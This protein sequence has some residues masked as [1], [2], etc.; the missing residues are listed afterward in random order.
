M[1]FSQRKGLKPIPQRLRPDQMPDELRSSL[2]NALHLSLWDSPGF[3]YTST[4]NYGA[5]TTFAR[6]LW[7]DYFKL[8][9]SG[10][11]SRPAEVI[12]WLQQYFF[13]CP[14]NEVYDFLEAVL[15]ATRNNKIVGHLDDVLK[16][17]LAAYRLIKNRVVEIT[18]EKEMAAL[19]EALQGG[20]GFAPA[21]AHLQQALE[22]LSDR[23]NPDFRNSIKE[24]IS[25]VEAAARAITGRQTATL[26][27]ALKVL[28]E[29]H[30]LHKAL[31]DGF[32]KLYGYT[33]DGDGIRHAMREESTVGRAEAKYF[34]LSCTSFVNYLRSR[35]A[36]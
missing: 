15:N 25:A 22:H 11:P 9:F 14:W 17:E 12:A 13:T 1:N 23:T 35:G 28:E 33:S 34:L 21:A 8:P 29:K 6:Q 16:R 19:E 18:D 32:L 36:A 5:V 24:S 3:Q 10:I 4:G 20:D 2:W 30:S 7:F 31:K 27:D 26:G